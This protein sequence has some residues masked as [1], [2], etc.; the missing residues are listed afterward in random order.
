MRLKNDHSFIG[1]ND[2][3][4]LAI[5]EQR[6]TCNDSGLKR[7]IKKINGRGTIEREMEKND[8]IF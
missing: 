1:K 3:D 5:F 6:V 8:Y 4:L 7:L 2:R